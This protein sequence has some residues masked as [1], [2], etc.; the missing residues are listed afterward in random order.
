MVAASRAAARSQAH[1]GCPQLMGT[2]RT[3]GAFIYIFLIPFFF[4][5]FFFFLQIFFFFEMPMSMQN[6]ALRRVESA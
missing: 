2:S 5:F 6:L 1:R 3:V 4:F